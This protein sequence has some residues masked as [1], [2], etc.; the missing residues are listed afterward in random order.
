MLKI[1][2]NFKVRYAGKMT[3]LGNSPTFV[4]RNHGRTGHGEI[5]DSFG[6]SSSMKSRIML[7]RLLKIYTNH[8][9]NLI[10]VFGK[11]RKKA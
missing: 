2:Y 5:L 4:I 8:D 11:R 10:T 3:K 7:F 6:G 9:Q 1:R